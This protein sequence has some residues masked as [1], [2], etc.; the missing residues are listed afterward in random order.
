MARQKAKLEIRS[1]RTRL[2]KQKV[3]KWEIPAVPAKYLDILLPPLSFESTEEGSSSFG[4]VLS[5]PFHASFRILK[6]RETSHVPIYKTKETFDGCQ[7]SNLFEISISAKTL[8]QIGLSLITVKS[9]FS[10]FHKCHF[11]FRP[12]KNFIQLLKKPTNLV[13][14]GETLIFKS[15]QFWTII[16]ETRRHSPCSARCCDMEAQ[17]YSVSTQLEWPKE[18]R[19]YHREGISYAG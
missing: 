18:G 8:K 4:K 17:R 1:K 12:I 5:C 2:P 7:N 10:T 13:G 15:F 14:N 19:S 9:G 3:R 6:T 11:R 16:C